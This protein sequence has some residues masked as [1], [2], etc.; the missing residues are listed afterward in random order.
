MRAAPYTNELITRRRAG[1]RIGLVVVALDWKAGQEFANKP[2]VARVVAPEGF[3][4][5]QAS[6]SA[7][8]SLD[9]VLVGGNDEARFYAAATALWR[10]EVA[11]LWGEFEDGYYRLTPALRGLWIADDGPLEARKLGA[12]LRQHRDSALL[13]AS[14]VYGAPAFAEARRGLFS[15]IFGDEAAAAMREV[16]LARHAAA[17]LLEKVAA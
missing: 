10:A 6:W 2:A 12:V 17:G 13:G 16:S 1:E 9:V 14:G 4:V 8:A 7:L 11:S 3:D 15:M 5:R